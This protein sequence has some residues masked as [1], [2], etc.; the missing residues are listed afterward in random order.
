MTKSKTFYRG[1]VYSTA[2]LHNSVQNPRS[3]SA[4]SSRVSLQP[5]ICCFFLCFCLFTNRVN[6][7]TSQSLNISLKPQVQFSLV[8]LLCPFY[9]L[10]PAESPTSLCFVDAWPLGRHNLY[11]SQLSPPATWQ[12]NSKK[13]P[14][15]QSSLFLGYSWIIILLGIAHPSF[16]RKE[17]CSGLFPV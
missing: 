13:Q 2:R 10:T 17:A 3:Y 14:A 7:C 1:K 6:S 4:T 11:F 12:T 15:Q 8:D 16:Q 9:Q 5:H